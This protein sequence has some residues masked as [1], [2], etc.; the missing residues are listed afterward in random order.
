MPDDP[1]Q[2]SIARGGHPQRAQPTGLA[3]ESERSASQHVRAMVATVFS[4]S[5]QR[6]QAATW[7]L[8]RGV[9]SAG[10]TELSPGTYML[11]A[12]TDGDSRWVEPMRRAWPD[13]ADRSVVKAVP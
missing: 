13:F 12:G 4:R 3:G 1:S 10:K 6:R 2:A 11:M 8:I 5:A 7:V 9:A